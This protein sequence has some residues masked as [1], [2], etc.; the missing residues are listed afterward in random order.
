[1]KGCFDWQREGLGEPDEVTSATREYRAE[2]DALQQFIDE[3]CVVGESMSAKFAELWNS[4]TSWC[5]EARVNQSEILTKPRFGRELQQRGFESFSGYR[6]VAMR[7]GIGLRLDDDPPP[8]PEPPE[9]KKPPS[10]TSEQD[11]TKPGSFV[12]SDD[13]TTGGFNPEPENSLNVGGVGLSEVP[14]QNSC[15]TAEN[16]EG[17][18]RFKPNTGFSNNESLTRENM[19]NGLNRLN[20]LNQDASTDEERNEK[21]REA[22]TTSPTVKEVYAAWLNNEATD[23]ELVGAVAKY[24]REPTGPDLRVEVFRAVAAM[25]GEDGEEETYGCV[26]NIGTEKIKTEKDLPEGY[27]YVGREV[28]DRRTN[29]IRFEE[30]V[31]HNPFKE[32]K[33][34]TF[35]K[36]LAKYEAYVLSKPDLI[37][38]L[39]ELSGKTL[40]CWCAPKPC[41]GDVLLRLAHRADDEGREA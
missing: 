21:A 30:S 24:L 6:N 2:Q 25:Q 16:R 3:C 19:E 37:E 33:D 11:S 23:D 39:P 29:R 18:N 34:G 9:D 32:G 7:S 1:V 26:M 27:V 36:V 12:T 40:V 14:P 13:K 5:D 17:F 10:P 15:K 31:W 4:N 20:G 41:H 22:L 28:R 35:E 38:R 8:P